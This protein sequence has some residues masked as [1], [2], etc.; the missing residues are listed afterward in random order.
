MKV[1]VFESNLMWSSKLLRSLRALG[2]EPVLLD[3]VPDSPQGA[4]VAIVNLAQAQ[5]DPAELVAALKASGIHTIGHAG[6]KEAELLELGRRI[7]VD[8][9]ATN[10]ELTFKIGD[11]IAQVAAT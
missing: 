6:H 9:V 8:T 1:L 11:L 2:Y 3:T 4:R 5:P 7:G 10:S